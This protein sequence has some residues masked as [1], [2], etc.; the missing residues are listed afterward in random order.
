MRRIETRAKSKVSSV[1]VKVGLGA[2]AD[3]TGTEGT[4]GVSDVVVVGIVVG[5]TVVAGGATEEVVS[6]VGVG[7][8]TIGIV[9]HMV[10]LEA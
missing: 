1:T 4:R 3:D 8:G 5:G 7:E 9:A 2:G 10:E 6:G